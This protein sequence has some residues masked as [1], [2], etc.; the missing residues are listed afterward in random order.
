[1][2]PAEMPAD[3]FANSEQELRRASRVEYTFD[4]LAQ[5]LVSEEELMRL[6]L[7]TYNDRAMYLNAL[8]VN[9]EGSYIDKSDNLLVSNNVNI[10]NAIDESLRQF[11]AKTIQFSK[12]NFDLF[13]ESFSKRIQL[14][15]LLTNASKVCTVLG[16]ACLAL[17]WKAICVIFL[18]L[19]LLLLACSRFFIDLG[20]T[21]IKVY[22]YLGLKSV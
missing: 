11:H 14:N 12:E 13:N 7:E 9:S 8:E 20:D 2:F 15:K 22:D 5:L 21:P 18:V 10:V 4:M 3:I 17:K 6:V 1:M 16:I 19:T